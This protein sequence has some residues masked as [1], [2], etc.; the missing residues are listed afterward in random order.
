MDAD[1]T[2]KA[3]LQAASKVVTI[4]SFR[5][6][7]GNELLEGL[8]SKGYVTLSFGTIGHGYVELTL[9]GT[10]ALLDAEGLDWRTGKRKS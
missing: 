8:V 3:G 6:V 1:E 5:K 9:E 2:I 7:L 4:E 10:R